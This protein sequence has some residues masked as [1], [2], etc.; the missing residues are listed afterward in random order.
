MKSN[1][2][3]CK[4]CFA[5][6]E[7]ALLALLALSFVEGSFAEGHFEI[8]IAKLLIGAAGYVAV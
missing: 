5:C 6:S 2:R 4:A 1:V 3:S 8:C 7:L